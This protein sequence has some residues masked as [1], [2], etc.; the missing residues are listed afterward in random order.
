MFSR[1]PS[2]IE[3][4]IVIPKYSAFRIKRGKQNAEES[5]LYLIYEDGV[6]GV[7]Y[8]YN[9][10]APGRSECD[11]KNVIFNLVL[12]IGIFR[13]SDD[14]VLQWMP[15]DLTDDKSR[16]VQLM[17]WCRQATWANAESVPCRFMASL[18]H[19]LKY[20]LRFVLT[21]TLHTL[22]CNDILRYNATWLHTCRIPSS[23]NGSSSSTKKN[24][25][26]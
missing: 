14:N 19:N 6:S 3:S 13:S 2:D 15:Q 4:N 17:V 11:S 7:L 23:A 24:H 9:S 1:Y 25:N 20:H 22:S 16:L 18:G 12:L 8:G 10:L 21:V 5:T 26:W